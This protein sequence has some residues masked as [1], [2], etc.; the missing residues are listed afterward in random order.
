MMH[1]QCNRQKTQYL[2]RLFNFRQLMALRDTNHPDEAFV[3]HFDKAFGQCLQSFSL[4]LY[5]IRDL[6]T[7]DEAIETLLSDDDRSRPDDPIRDDMTTD[8]ENDW[9]LHS[10]KAM[11]ARYRFNQ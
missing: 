11:E 3:D 10:A 4:P 7:A 5:N 1:C 6:V 2:K 9:F 8:D